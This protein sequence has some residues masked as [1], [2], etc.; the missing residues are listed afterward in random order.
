M[1]L[2]LS[3]LHHTDSKVA[4]AVLDLAIGLVITLLV[5]SIAHSA[6]RPAVPASSER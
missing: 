1:V 3:L 6:V 4:T 2:P 5:V